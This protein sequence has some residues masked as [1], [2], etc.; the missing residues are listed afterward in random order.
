MSLW[1]INYLANAIPLLEAEEQQLR[2]VA[3]RA[4]NVDRRSYERLIHTLQR[5]AAPYVAPEPVQ[6]A[7]TPEQKRQA[8][9]YL[10]ALGA[11]VV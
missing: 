7:Q 10:K 2:I 4:G 1:Q 8:A 5:M 11:R 9:E 6:M 3:A